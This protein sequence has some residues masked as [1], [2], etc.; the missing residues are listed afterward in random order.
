MTELF[1]SFSQY[2]ANL[3][4]LEL[5]AM[6]LSL[7]YVVLAAQGSIWCWPA[8][9][10]STS[11][12]VIIFYDVSLLMD[13]ALN[14]YYLLMAVYGYWLWQK[15]PTENSAATESSTT[16]V[17]VSH[18]LNWHVKVCALLVMISLALGF[19]MSNYTSADFAYLDTF[20]TVFA[21]FAT[22]LVTQKVLENWLYWLVIDCVSI[23]LYIEKALLA[24]AFL[25]IIYLI[26]A[27]YGYIKWLGIYR[28]HNQTNLSLT[29]TG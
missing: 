16:F 9:F 20:T 1:T 18:S 28:R 22:Y 4:W 19:V 8:A 10:I 21:V 7:A 27:T 29:S 23:Y 25:F 15:A 17:V 26:I 2:T 12:Y 5:L 11:I 24:T 13:S 3:P 6:L 14:G